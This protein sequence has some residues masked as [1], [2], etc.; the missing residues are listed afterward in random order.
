[1]KREILKLSSW[2]RTCVKKGNLFGGCNEKECLLDHIH[3]RA[4]SRR[5]VHDDDNKGIVS[6]F[7]QLQLKPSFLNTD[8]ALDKGSGSNA[9][10]HIL[11]G[12]GDS[13]A[14]GRLYIVD[15]RDQVKGGFRCIGAGVVKEN[16]QSEGCV[17]LIS[18]PNEQPT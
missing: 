1:M 16:R 4:V 10:A 11:T 13:E 18:I 9:H 14:V 3:K 5:L 15:V 6:T 7:K 8:R 12:V 17:L 2:K